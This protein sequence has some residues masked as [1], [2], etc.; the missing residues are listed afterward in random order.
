MWVNPKG[1]L[2]HG[3][4][5][6]QGIPNEMVESKTGLADGKWHHTTVT[7]DQKKMTVYVD[8]ILE[9]EK[10]YTSIEDV[11]NHPLTIGGDL[12][13]FNLPLPCWWGQN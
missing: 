3:H 7:F 13:N 10:K 9:F 2:H 6:A 5:K 12:N 11:I 1:P 4:K 8:G